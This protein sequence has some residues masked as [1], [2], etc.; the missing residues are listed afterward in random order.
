[1]PKDGVK[2]QDLITVKEASIMAGKSVATIRS[3]VRKGKVTGFKEDVSNHSSPLLISTEE[4]KTY[5]H[6]GATLTHPNNTGRPTIP[7]VSI[8]NKEQEIQTLKNELELLR[9]EIAF[10]DE[11]IEDFQSFI[12]TLKELLEQRDKE[13]KALREQ[14]NLSLSRETEKQEEISKLLKWANLPFWKRWRNDLRL[15]EG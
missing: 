1:M 2:P 3:W 15:L 9:K 12:F 4:L 8:Q 6:T 7:S 14:L 11:R 13:A 5:L 10:K